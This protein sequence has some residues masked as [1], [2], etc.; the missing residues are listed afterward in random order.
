MRA[1]KKLIAK[2]DGYE[3]IVKIDGDGQF[4]IE[5]IAKILKI[6]KKVIT[7]ILNLIDFGR[8]E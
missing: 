8:V 2:V 3:M 7:N 5:D 4:L 6:A 1:T